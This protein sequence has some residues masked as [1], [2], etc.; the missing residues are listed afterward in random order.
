MSLLAVAMAEKMR[1]ERINERLRAAV[2]NRF[3][4]LPHRRWESTARAERVRCMGVYEACAEAVERY[5]I[6]NEFCRTVK[7]VV[8][9]MGAVPIRDVA[10]RHMFA[11]MRRRLA[12]GDKAAVAAETKRWYARAQQGGDFVDIEPGGNLRTLPQGVRRGSPVEARQMAAAA[13]AA[14]Y[15]KARDLYWKLERDLRVWELYAMEARTVTEIAEAMGIGRDAVH[16]TIKRVRAQMAAG[17][18]DQDEDSDDA[19]ENG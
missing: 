3:E 19:E 10:G 1:R 14:H 5:A 16:R 12:P 17:R 9:K 8:V 13:G 4:V 15:D 6:T 11:F 7:Q 18:G 2:K